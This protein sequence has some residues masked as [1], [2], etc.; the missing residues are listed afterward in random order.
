MLITPHV[1]AGAALASVFPNTLSGKLAGFMVGWVSH[2]VLDAFPHWERIFGPHDN[3]DLRKKPYS[4]WPNHVFVQAFMDTIIG[5]ILLVWL[6]GRTDVYFCWQSTLFWGGVGGMLPD[7]LDNVPAWQNYTKNVRLWRAIER[8]HRNVHI[9]AVR[10][11]KLPK[12]TGLITQLIAITV[13]L[14]VII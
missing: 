1:L 13:S 3:L 6:S 5:F 8:L 7:V 14:Y 9:P 12:Y 2:Y 10:Q 4:K 11:R